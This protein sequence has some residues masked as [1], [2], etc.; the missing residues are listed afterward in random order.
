M[1]R[2]T[3]VRISREGLYYTI[4]VL[5]VLIGAVSRQLNLLM[6]LGSVLAGPLLFSL[7]YGRIMLSRV[8]VERKLPPLLRADQRLIVDVSVT[9]ARR[10]LGV[11]ALE[12]EDVV[13]REGSPQAPGE[14]V[15]A[16]VFF[17]RIAGRETRQVSYAGYL[18]RRGRY[19]FGPLRLSTRFPL[20]LVRHSIVLDQGDALLVHPKFGRLTRQRAQEVREDAAGAQ[21]MQRRGLLEA[22]FYGLRDWRPGDSRRWIH[23]RTSARRGSL[24]VRQFEQRRTADLALLVDLWQPT[25]AG[26]E[27][28][29]SVE[30]AVSFVATVIA[31]ACRQP[32]HNLILGLAAQESLYRSGAASGL[33]FREQMDALALAKAHDEAHFPPSL[34]HVLALVPP[35]IPVWIVSTRKIDWDAFGAA[36]AQRDARVAG[37]TF[38]SVNVASDE[39]AQYFHV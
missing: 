17:P 15:T 2:Q 28:L 1:A 6:L 19:R 32:G 4:V 7:M 35:S 33:F 10:W 13:A 31:E 8:V 38:R 25:R 37:R 22:D 34:G 36:A 14:Q 29:E 3:Q 27:H 21:R 39:L 23:W 11:W 24:V 18:P 12:I 30:T 20:G 16:G 9:N 26:E 5:A